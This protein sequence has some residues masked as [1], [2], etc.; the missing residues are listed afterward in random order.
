MR[1]NRDIGEGTYGR[2]MGCIS[3]ST[4][5]PL[6]PMGFSHTWRRAGT[7]GAVAPSQPGRFIGP[8]TSHP[9]TRL[10]PNPS[11]PMTKVLPFP[12]QPNADIGRRLSP[13][14]DSI[15]KLKGVLVGGWANLGG[16]IHRVGGL[17]PEIVE[18]VHVLLLTEEAAFMVGRV[19]SF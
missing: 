2:G 1:E 5:L 3:A 18:F 7:G 13:S 6:R 12:E 11:H 15:D 10:A 9:L 8:I 16:R 17:P 14:H 4:S 19:K